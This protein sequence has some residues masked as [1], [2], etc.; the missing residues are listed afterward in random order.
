MSCGKK[1]F[2]IFVA[3]I[4]IAHFVYPF[5]HTSKKIHKMRS[6]NTQN[7]QRNSIYQILIYND[8][9]KISLKYIL[10]R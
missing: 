7:A 5:Y 6:E 8:M 10:M 9:K 4:I 2:I 3:E 1:E